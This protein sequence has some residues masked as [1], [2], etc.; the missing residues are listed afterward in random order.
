MQLC[1]LC[2]GLNRLKPCD[3]QIA[4][5]EVKDEIRHVYAPEVGRSGGAAGG[6][7]NRRKV[8]GCVTNSPG[9]Q[10]ESSNEKGCVALDHLLR[11]KSATVIL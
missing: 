5:G 4:F 7:R 3:M 11:C 10:I 9:T 1:L 6:E 2:P 8:R